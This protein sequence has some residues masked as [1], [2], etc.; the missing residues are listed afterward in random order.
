M[1]KD[2]QIEQKWILQNTGSQIWPA[3]TIFKQ[4][5]G[6][7]IENVIDSDILPGQT[8]TFTVTIVAPSAHSYNACEEISF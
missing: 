8:H 6:G 3:F 7:S 1:G 5:K 4:I 2:T